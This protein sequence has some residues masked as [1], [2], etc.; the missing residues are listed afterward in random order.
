MFLAESLAVKTHGTVPVRSVA[1]SYLSRST[2]TSRSEE[3]TIELIVLRR[4]L[5]ILAT[6]STIQFNTIPRNRSKRANKP[7][8]PARISISS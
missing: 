1:A 2:F 5:S 8:L 4:E 3:L 6:L 7:G